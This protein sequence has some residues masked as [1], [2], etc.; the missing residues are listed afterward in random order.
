M[1]KALIGHLDGDLRGTAR[2]SIENARLRARVVELEALVRSLAEENDRLLV[3]HPAA[4]GDRA[5]DEAL[6][7]A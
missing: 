4:T 2:L 1:A 5:R 6:L 7:P 3:T